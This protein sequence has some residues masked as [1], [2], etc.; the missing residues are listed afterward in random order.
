MLS[1]CPSCLSQVSHAD[2]LFDVTC[3]CGTHFSPFLNVDSGIESSNS[4]EA[5]PLTEFADTTPLND[6]SESN[7]AFADI[8]NFGEAL[9]SDN[10]PP[11]TPPPVAKT[12]KAAAKTAK[13][14]ETPLTAAPVLTSS[15]LITRGSMLQGYEIETYLS[16]VSLWS[17][18]EP[19]DQNPM[20]PAFSTLWETATKAGAN[21]VIDIHWS[22]SPD[23]TRV[24]IS[25]T[26][27]RCQAK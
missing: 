9:G 27:V 10:E 22:L 20:K 16:P 5:K 26:P 4:P 15:F 7:E 3:E 2:H 24:L 19:T 21:A 8:R 17:D 25:G 6:F 1:T 23:C 13:T 14:A 12:E 18:L 11:V